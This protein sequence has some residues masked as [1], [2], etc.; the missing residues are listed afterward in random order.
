[1]GRP[2][3]VEYRGAIYHITSRGKVKAFGVKQ[4]EIQS[5]RSRSNTAR[6]VAMYLVQRYSGVGECGG[7]KAVRRNSLQCGKQGIGEVE[8]GDDFRQE[9]NELGG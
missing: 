9:I 4:R 6:K 2:L 8:R 7:G 5:K 3:R 1:M